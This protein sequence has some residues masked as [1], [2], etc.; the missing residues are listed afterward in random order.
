MWM[1]SNYIRK[2]KNEMI[3]GKKSI[4]KLVS[5]ALIACLG[6]S[7]VGCGGDEF[8][9]PY[10]GL[11]LAEYVTVGDYID[12]EVTKQKVKVTDDEVQAEIMTRLQA[13][14]KQ[15]EVKEGT[16]K[17]TDSVRIAY[18]GKL[19]GEAFQGGS[20]GDEGT[21]ITLGN[22]G[23]IDGFDDGVIG[24]K[25]GE[26]KDLDLTFPE[27]YGNAELAGQAVVFEVKLLAIVKTETPEY[28]VEFVKANSNA[29]TIEDYEALVKKELEEKKELTA[30]NNVKDQLW[31]LI[32]EGSK[33]EKYPE[34][35]LEKSK[36]ESEDYYLSYAKQYGMELNEFL[37]TYMGMDEKAYKE[38]QQEYAE[39]MVAQ[40]MVMYS[41]AQAENITLSK[42]EYDTELKAFME[43]QGIDDAAAFEEMY[44]MSFEEYA[45]KDNLTKSFLLEK[46]LDFVIENAKVKVE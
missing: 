42:S 4:T 36:K 21:I 1:K 25:V 41:I 9:N 11:N 29:K 12:L 2:G 39:A 28:D 19:N 33:V 44:G 8:E 31:A 35:I 24:M 27:N 30:E 43:E 32:M 3:R 5:L 14:S 34:D 23:H 45:G 13:A 40:E 26:E 7:L 18:V 37:E 17:L 6:T 38:Y 22:S 46:V 10:E 20:T 15:V 16:A